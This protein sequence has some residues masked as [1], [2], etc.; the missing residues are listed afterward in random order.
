MKTARKALLIVLCA[1]LLIVAS[2]MGTLAYLTDTADKVTNTFTVG[3]VSFAE[4]PIDEAVASEY[5]VADVTARTAEGNEYKLIPGHNYAKDPVIYMSATTEDA[6]LFVKIHNGIAPIEAADNTINAQML[7]NGW[8]VIDA[9]N[10]IYGKTDSVTKDQEIATFTE[11][12]IDTQAN[13]AAYDDAVIAIE[14]Y[15]VQKDG[16]ASVS[17]AWE[18][19][20]LSAWLAS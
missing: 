4:T 10:G 6:W 3:N 16:L 1:I 15:A 12:T 11:F 13:V 14:A 17:A 5:G 19:A 9:T 20:P 2:V 8:E 7:D 18:A